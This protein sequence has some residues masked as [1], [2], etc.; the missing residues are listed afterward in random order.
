M[1]RRADQSK[2]AQIRAIAFAFFEAL[3]E[4]H[5]VLKLQASRK[6]FFILF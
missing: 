4:L 6:Q 2:G 1:Q 3:R 5:A